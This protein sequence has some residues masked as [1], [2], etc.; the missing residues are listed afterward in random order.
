MET[1]CFETHL[2]AK[3]RTVGRK[4]MRT[5]KFITFLLLVSTKIFGQR[6]SDSEIKDVFKS[7]I[8]DKRQVFLLPSIDSFY[9]KEIKQSLSTN[10]FRRR[11]KF[12]DSDKEVYDTLYFTKAERLYV[13]SFIQALATFK[14]TDSEKDKVGLENFSL[15][16]NDQPKIHPDFDYIVYTIAKPVFIRQDSICFLFYDCSC[17]SLC[18]YSELIILTR[19]G[20]K[21]LKWLTIF[22]SA[23]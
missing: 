12:S 17:G 22:Q 23:S 11:I 8:Q 5:L 1:F 2:N 19:Q 18:G 6:I 4:F 9:I 10:S 21:W 13:D 7:Y 14:W 20:N 16:K 15:I 3:F